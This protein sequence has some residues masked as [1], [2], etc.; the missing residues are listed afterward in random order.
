M[1]DT[2]LNFPYRVEYKKEIDNLDDESFFDD[3]RQKYRENFVSQYTESGGGGV[4]FFCNQISIYH[5]D[6]CTVAL[7]PKL[8]GAGLKII[9]KEKE[10]VFSKL[11]QIAKK[12]NL[13]IE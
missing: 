9:G 11:E 10:K 1:R 12:R 2:I 6:N 8:N 7:K 3:V 13:K 5:I 4:F